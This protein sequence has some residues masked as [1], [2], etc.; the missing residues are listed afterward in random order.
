MSD[1]LFDF[2]NENYIQDFHMNHRDYLYH[3]LDDKIDWD[4]QLIAISRLLKRNT[5]AS[6]ND[7]KE[8]DNDA[9]N[10]KTYNGKYKDH[11]IDEHIHLMHMSVFHD[12]AASMA[13]IGMII[14]FIERISHYFF[15]RMGRL[16]TEKN[17]SPPPNKRWSV[18]TEDE[19]SRWDCSLYLSSKEVK[20][21]FYAGF[22]Q[23][24]KATGLLKYIPKS[25]MTWLDAMIFY[26]NYMFHNGF[27]WGEESKHKF[28][29]TITK[30][31]WN[32]YFSFSK[33]SNDPWIFTINQEFINKSPDLINEFLD[34]LASYC[35]DLPEEIWT[36]QDNRLPGY[37]VSTSK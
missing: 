30:K 27:E 37:L 8:I 33:R 9:N 6:L 14:P 18:P 12:A 7:Q 21:N 4:S 34:C 16:Y 19:A 28:Q 24:A 25:M 32:K 10:L 36:I 31:S 3:I 17:L 5:L 29:E 11:Y 13:A 15:E 1:I 23:L 20:K 2:E 26:R 22:T 35:K